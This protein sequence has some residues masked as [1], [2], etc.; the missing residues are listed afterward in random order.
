M[1][2]AKKKTKLGSNE[3]TKMKIYYSRSR[4]LRNSQ[5]LPRLGQRIEEQR[6]MRLSQTTV[7]RV[8]QRKERQKGSWLT[9]RRTS[10]CMVEVL[11]GW[12]SWWS[13]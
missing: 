10:T 7:G 11:E 8:G 3:E 1:E 6:K 13:A 9:G 2:H 5:W 12:S 4:Q